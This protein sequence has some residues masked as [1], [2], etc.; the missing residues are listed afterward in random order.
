[1]SGEA[2][3]RQ[4]PAWCMQVHPVKGNV[5]FASAQSGWSFTLRSFAQLYADVHGTFIDVDKFTER[6]WGD[7]YFNKDTRKFSK[8]QEGDMQRSFVHFIMEPLY[9]IYTQVGFNTAPAPRSLDIALCLH[10]DIAQSRLF[11]SAGATF[12]LYAGDR[13]A[14][15]QSEA[16]FGRVWRVSQALFIWARCETPAE[17]G[18]QRHLRQ[19][20]WSCGSYGSAFPVVKGRERQEGVLCPLMAMTTWSTPC[21]SWALTS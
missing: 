19:R 18:L 12:G 20:Y 13:R 11:I 9:K 7:I 5:G 8:K 10:H 3:D 14:R 4:D 21:R 2:C 1:M 17:G 16:C 15:D 6:M